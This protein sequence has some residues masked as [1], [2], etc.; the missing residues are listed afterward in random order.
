MMDKQATPA[1]PENYPVSHTPL[2]TDPCYQV[3]F[4]LTSGQ[5]EAGEHPPAGQILPFL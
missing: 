3:S 5:G 4:Q 2:A 1:R